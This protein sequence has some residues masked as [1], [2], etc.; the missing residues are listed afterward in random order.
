M[1]LFF[2]FLSDDSWRRISFSF[3]FFCTISKSKV[4]EN[5]DSFRVES[6][7]SLSSRLYITTTRIR[8]ISVGSFVSSGQK[9]ESNEEDLRA[10]KS[11]VGTG[12]V[13]R[14][15]KGAK[16]GG[17]KTCIPL[18]W[19]RQTRENNDYDFRAAPCKR[20]DGNDSILPQTLPP[21]TLIPSS[22]CSMSVEMPACTRDNKN[23]PASITLI[24]E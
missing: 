22:L 20:W 14:V 9:E 24:G 3:F 18:G 7:L 12:F 10:L 19:P 16:K 1:F 4:R 6:F 13:S 5:E 17:K 2:F 11:A 23:I 21:Y 8:R 15:T